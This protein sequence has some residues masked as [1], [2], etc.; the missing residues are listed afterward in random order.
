MRA[1]SSP[2]IGPRCVQRLHLAVDGHRV[3]EAGGPAQHIGV[4]GQ[5]L[6]QDREKSVVSWGEASTKTTGQG[7]GLTDR[8][9]GLCHRRPGNRAKSAS[10]EWSSH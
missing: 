6:G 9:R 10:L 8:S 5:D 2:V 7:R 1:S 3:I 4:R